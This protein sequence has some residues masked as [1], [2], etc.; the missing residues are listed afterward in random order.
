MYPDNR[1]LTASA[2]SDT[3]EDLKAD[4]NTGHLLSSGPLC[5]MVYRTGDEV[6]IPQLRLREAK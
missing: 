3:A 5:H 6:Y 1:L 4:G 2:T